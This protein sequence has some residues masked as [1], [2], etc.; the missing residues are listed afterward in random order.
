MSMAARGDAF[1]EVHTRARPSWRRDRYSGGTLREKRVVAGVA[2]SGRV[3]VCGRM[4]EVSMSES[5]RGSAGPGEGRGA[6]TTAGTTDSAL[7]RKTEALPVP[8]PNRNAVGVVAAGGVYG[9]SDRW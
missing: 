3:C 2:E 7:S 6:A 1:G 8:V 9:G 5:E 4:G